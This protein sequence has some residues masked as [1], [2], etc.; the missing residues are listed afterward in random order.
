MNNQYF[1]FKPSARLTSYI[2]KIKEMRISRGTV[3]KWRIGKDYAI[4]K[5]EQIYVKASNNRG[6]LKSALE[7][8]KSFLIKKDDGQLIMKMAAEIEKA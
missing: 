5:V 7:N 6:P 8:I 3:V 2:I 4:G 1:P